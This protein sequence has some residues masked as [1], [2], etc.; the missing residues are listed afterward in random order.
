MLLFFI[1][2]LAGGA[3]LLFPL[4]WVNGRSEAK[5][6]PAPSP[7]P[8]TECLLEPGIFQRQA[9]W[10]AGLKCLERRVGRG[11]NFSVVM[12]R[13]GVGPAEVDEIVRSV[14]DLTDLTKIKAGA[15]IKLY[16]EPQTGRLSRLDYLEDGQPRLLLVNTPA[17]WTGSLR[18]GAPVRLRA[19]AAGRIKNSLWES[20]VGSCDLDPE[21]IMSFADIFAYDVDFFTEVQEGDEFSLLYE[22]NYQGG[23]RVGSGRILAARFVT[24]GEVKEAF[25]HEDA[26]RQSGY[27]DAEGR[28]LKK[29]FLKSPL[30]YRRISS[31]FSRSRLHPILKIRRPHLGVDYSAPTGTPVEALGSGVISFA[32]RKGGYG[33]FIVIN[34][35]SNFT[36]MYGHLSGFA[37][38]IKKGVRVNQGQ[39]IGF[40]GATGL[41]TGPH[42]DFRVQEK[43]SFIDPLS[44]RMKP[45]A[46]VA[47]G[48]KQGFLKA[49]APRRA[50]M[51][52]ASASDK[53]KER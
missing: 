26:R 22:E 36:T 53:S 39:L 1:L 51:S 32:G 49:V 19:A 17:G 16:R 2:A 47:P 11:E 37:R 25:F 9:D 10:K 24:G 30:Q 43:G 3:C 28:S 40:V 31:Y 12:D 23:R 15:A 13:L 8:V 44:V 52:R 21:L 14:G 6:E 38:G 48:E 20:A 46:P 41:A 7:S 33:N 4:G 5:N 50:E 29:M 35:G 42:L 34:H 27:Y 18:E 45:A